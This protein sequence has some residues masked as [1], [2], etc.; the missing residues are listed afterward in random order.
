M[1]DLSHLRRVGREA[2]TVSTT[3]VGL[4]VATRNEAAANE[5]VLAMIQVLSQPIRFRVDGTAPT[6][7]T[8]NR[9]NTNDILEVW[10]YEDQRNFS[11][12]REGGTN[13]TLE[14][15]YYTK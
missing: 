5:A 4:T 11:A 14:V 12:I 10:G 15:N 7:T 13:A 3:A 6:S 1:A 2:I 8:G 9:A